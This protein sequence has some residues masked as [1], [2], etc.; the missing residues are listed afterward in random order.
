[1]R[2]GVNVPSLRESVEINASPEVVWNVLADVSVL[3]EL[4]SS[5]IEVE[6]D[7]LLN[8]V[9]QTFVQTVKFAR[10]DWTSEW[11]VEEVEPTRLLKIV[12]SLPGGTPYTMT[13][14]LQPLNDGEKTR[15]SIQGDY[16]LPFG[17]LGRMIDHLGAEKRARGELNEVLNGVAHLAEKNGSTAGSSD[18]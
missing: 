8:H 1:M 17:V 14:K 5:T 10:K 15:L 7:G 16:E 9:G 4:S 18:G 6:T 3:P 13:E 11:R 2:P 12:G